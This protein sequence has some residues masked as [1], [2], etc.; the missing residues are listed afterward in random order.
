MYSV[1]WGKDSGDKDIIATGG[2]DKT[3]IIWDMENDKLVPRVKSGYEFGNRNF[4][5]FCREIPNEKNRKPELVSNSD[6]IP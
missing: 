6:F 1:G 4:S 2:K 5:G 3:V